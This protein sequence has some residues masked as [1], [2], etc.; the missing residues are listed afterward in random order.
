MNFKKIKNILFIHLGIL[1]LSVGI[2]FFKI[3]N[4]FITG[5]VSGIATALGKITPIISVAG[6]IFIINIFL[7]FV[8]FIFLG[9]QTGAVTI[10][11]SIMFSV[12][13]GVFEVL[14][15]LSHPLTNQPLLELVYGI[16]LTGIGSAIL[17][18]CNASSGGTDII[19]LILKKFTS[20]NVGRALLYTDFV[21]AIS[22][23]FVFGV[24]AGLFSMLGL[25]AKAFLID[26]V[27]DNIN[28]FKYFIVITERPDEIVNYVMNEM[29]HGVTVSEV[30]G[31]FTGEKKYMLHT[32]CKRMEAIYLRKM[33]KAVDENAF[34]I[35]TTSN[36]IIG[37]G[38][39]SV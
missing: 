15:P 10:Y 21:V 17:F 39:R 33:V 30:K 20:L 23:F 18:N 14:F 36:E 16:V 26:A 38:F 3:P 11:C 7:I 27:I 25:F 22:S 6:W 35:I 31:G 5:G 37:R 13:T 12:V 24:Q 28:S 4:G 1:M 32:V 29:R 8:G 34:T 9:K 19:A 2:Y